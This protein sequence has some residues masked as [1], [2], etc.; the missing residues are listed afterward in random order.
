[1]TLS[2]DERRMLKEAVAE[3]RLARVLLFDAEVNMRDCLYCG[4]A[5]PATRPNR[6]YCC[7][8]HKKYGW[9]TLTPQGRLWANAKKRRLRAAKKAQV[10]A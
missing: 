1:M 4:N 3:V 9:A 10:A 5:F 8:Q 6:R 7:S 2:F